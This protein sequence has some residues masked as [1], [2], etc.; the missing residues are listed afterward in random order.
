M[1]T[2]ENC[3]TLVKSA[4]QALNESD[5]SGNDAYTRGT[6]ATGH[7]ENSY[8]VDKINLSQE[9]IYDYLLKRIPEEFFETASLVGVDSVFTLPANFGKLLYFKD[10]R[11]LQVFPMRERDRRLESAT[12]SDRLY[13]KR[14]TTLV[15]DKAG[16]T[17][18]YTL[19][20]HRKA[21]DLDYG[22]STAGG[23]LSITL[24]TS[25]KKLVDYYNG[26]IIENISDD[27]VDTISD[28][29]T[30][31]VATIGTETGAASKYY[32][33]V[34]DLPDQFHK[35]ISP[36]AVLL[37]KRES[38]LSEEKPSN[39]DEDSF[40][41]SIREAF[42]AYSGAPDDVEPGSIFEDFHPPVTGGIRIV[43]DA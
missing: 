43:S 23:S 16:V 5:R 29:T 1:P 39:A 41:E 7:Y 36:K 10:D 30:G 9:F 4:R 37:I 2:Y 3:Y 22:L 14:G 19:F 25:A 21:R 28:Y 32:G 42:R 6:D 11:G 31:R 15:L 34:S 13:T 18:T 33:I 26:M 24:A 17:D 38:P 27:W 8:I 35:F 20:Y 12:G 40:L